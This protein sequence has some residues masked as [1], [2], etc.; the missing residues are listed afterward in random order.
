MLQH[1]RYGLRTLTRAPGF[2][3][4]AILCL[5][6]GIGATTAIFSIVNTVL[7]RPLPYRD[8]G[9]LVRLYTEFPSFGDRSLTRFWM[10]VP[11][12]FRLKDSASNSFESFGAYYIAGSNLSGSGQQPIRVTTGYATASGLAALGVQPKLGRLFTDPEDR[13][14]APQTLLLSESLWKQAFGGDPHII[15]REIYQDSAKCTIIGVMPSGFVF[16]PG[17][18]DPPQAWGPLQLDPS[19]RAT[20]SHF[21]SVFARLRPRTGFFDGKNEID[22]VVARLGEGFSPN[23]HTLHPKLHPVT[24]YSMVDE[25]IGNVRKA[26]LLLLGAVGFLLIIACVNVVNLILARSEARQRDTALRRALGA[27]RGQ[28]IRQYLTEGGLLSAT[29]ALLGTFLAFATIRLVA[30]ANAGSIPR[31]DELSLDWRVLLFTCAVAALIGVF[32]G[33]APLSHASAIHVSETLKSAGGRMSASLSSNRFRGFLVAGQIAMAFVLLAGASLMINGF[34]RLE[35]VRAGFDPSGLLTFNLSLPSASYQAP[36]TRKA[37]WQRLEDKLASI[38]GVESVALMSG[39]PPVRRVNENDTQ[40]EGWVRSPGAPQQSVV[41]YQAVSS[42]FFQTLG[43]HLVDGRFLQCQDVNPDFPGVM[44]NQVMAHTFW[45]YTSAIG[46]RIRPGFQGPW[47][48]I[49][50][51]VADVK[52]HGVDR[53]TDTE[54]F[55]PYQATPFGGFGLSNFSVA[56]KTQ[57]DPKRLANAARG[58]VASIDP[59]LPMADIRSMEEVMQ[60]ANARPRFYTLVLSMFSAL[61]LTLAALGVYGIMSYAVTRRTT[62]FGIRMALGA[63]PV[64]LFGGVIGQGLLLT[65]AGAVLG[66]VSAFFLTRLLQGLVFGVQTFDVKSFLVTAAVLVAATILATS[67]PAARVIRI[68]PVQALREE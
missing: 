19:N 43:I 42:R 56:I 5:A 65:A 45:P 9:R 10:S 59:S 57:G 66:S 52:N 32:F 44:I 24:M 49:V 68:Q 25:A 63:E 1:L 15:G 14:G 16:P 31:V 55:T 11:E 41:Y 48:T 35:Q 7:L 61:A 21:L 47:Y 64:K 33:F 36:A 13:P 6:L 34:L 30:A 4:S 29:S 60:R 17:E 51:I 67:V 39:L 58:V 23:N 22:R 20:G 50:G 53:A 12:Y 40:I 62:E 8:S 46:R 38:P 3:I 26:I 28:L 37:L 18:T 2:T 27:S 54:I